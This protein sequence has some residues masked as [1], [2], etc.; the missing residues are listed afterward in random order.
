M[1][2]I[3]I[4]R[5]KLSS[6]YDRMNLQCNQNKGEIIRDGVIRTS[7]QGNLLKLW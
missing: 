7:N 2:T 5:D 1:L 3:K 6:N 4:I